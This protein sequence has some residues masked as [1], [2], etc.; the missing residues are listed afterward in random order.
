[1]IH[2]VPGRRL[3]GSPPSGL[4][5]ASINTRSPEQNPALARESS[6]RV[7]PVSSSL[8]CILFPRFN[9]AT[10]PSLRGKPP[11]VSYSIAFGL[12]DVNAHTPRW[13][14]TCRF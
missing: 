6:A 8:A 9:R 1:M 5:G 3:I 13:A 11:A 2:L 12:V 10:V 14:L 7:P 4:D